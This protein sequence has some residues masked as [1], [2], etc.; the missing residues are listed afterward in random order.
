MA[1]TN[2]YQ[3]YQE[4]QVLTAGRGK[5][6]L[7]AYDGA[8]RFLRQARG[9]MA[10]RAYEQQNSCIV[11]AERLI[12][13]LIY[14][15]DAKANPELAHRLTLIYEYLFNRLIEANVADDVDALD[16]VTGHLVEMRSAWAE[17]DRN[18][19]VSAERIEKTP[20]VALAR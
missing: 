1:Y 6:L 5:L 15:L 7:M 19:S 4:S 8:I 18:H 13:E 2:A 16:E 14:T 17:A 9:H 12:L 3:Q 10:V 20:Y 11:K